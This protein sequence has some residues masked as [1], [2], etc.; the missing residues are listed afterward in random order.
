MHRAESRPGHSTVVLI[1]LLETVYCELNRQDS[2]SGP[3]RLVD[4]EHMGDS[5]CGRDCC[6]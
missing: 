1:R 5:V 2:G 3:A 4:V 6:C